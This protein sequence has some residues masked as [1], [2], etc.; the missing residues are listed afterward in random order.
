MGARIDKGED[1][2]KL[3]SI[4]QRRPIGDA[5][6]VGLAC[7]F[8]EE[9]KNRMIQGVRM[10]AEIL[11]IF[12]AYP[13]WGGAGGS[14]AIGYSGPWRK[15]SDVWIARCFVSVY[16]WLFALVFMVLMGRIEGV[17]ELM[18]CRMNQ[19]SINHI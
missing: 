18:A 15:G 16:F 17:E 1:E 3:L 12:L 7:G 10:V 19:L 9:V 4:G 6:T 5:G 14:R 11:S 2:S 13:V 8:Y